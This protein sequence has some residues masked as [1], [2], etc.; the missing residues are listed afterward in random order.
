MEKVDFKGEFYFETPVYQIGYFL[1]LGSLI[2]VLEGIYFV[3]PI[4]AIM[5]VFILT[6]RYG[7]EMDPTKKLYKDYIRLLGWKKGEYLPYNDLLYLSIVQKRMKQKLRMRIA[8]SIIYFEVYQGYLKLD[9]ENIY[10][11]NSKKKMG[12]IRKMND[13]GE[14][15]GV[16]VKDFSEN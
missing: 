16:E 9:H 11:T 6:T 1:I 3:A 8:S 4:I 15:L 10:L 13:F 7:L 12:L 14:R 2:L 5:G